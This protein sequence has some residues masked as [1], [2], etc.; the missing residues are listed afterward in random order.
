MTSTIFSRVFAFAALSIYCVVGGIQVDAADHTD[1]PLARTNGTLDINDLYAFQSP[2]RPENLTMIMMVNPFAGVL[3]P[4]TFNTRAVYEFNVDT[5]NDAVPNFAFRIY[6]SSPRRGSQRFIVVQANGRPLVSGETGK[7]TTIRSGGF[8]TAGQFDD[9]FFFDSAG[10]N[11]GLAFTGTDFFAGNNVSA[12][13]LEVPRSMFGTNNISVYARTLNGASQFDRVGRPAINTVLIGAG[14][15]DAFNLATPNQDV[16][17]FTPDVLA[18]LMSLG[19]T[20]TEAESLAGLLLPD[21]LTIDTSS[22]SGFL[23]GRQLAND[24]IDAELNLLTKGA[25]TGDGVDANDKAFSNTFPYLA[26][27]HVIAAQ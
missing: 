24:V 13:V 15:K 6:F 9:P 1:S 26:A 21:V 23:N 14:R 27:P 20:Q 16:A 8:V 11:N 2:Q 19:N 5:N 17:R 4:T 22:T 7:T 18:S 3:S 10:F 25:V 12:I